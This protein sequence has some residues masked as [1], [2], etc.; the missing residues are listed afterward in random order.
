MAFFICDGNQSDE[1]TKSSNFAYTI[2]EAA[3]ALKIGR[4]RLYELLTSGALPAKKIGRK[5]IILRT[6]LEA[7]F[8]GLNSY[9]VFRS[10]QKGG[11]CEK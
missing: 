9:S 10:Q 8:A 11:D 7:F 1:P 6:D 2:P 3:A 4:T 5:T